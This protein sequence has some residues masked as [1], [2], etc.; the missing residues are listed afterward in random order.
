[1][2]DRAWL[3]TIETTHQGGVP[4][5]VDALYRMMTGWGVE[6]TVTW[7]QSVLEDVTP[8]GRIVRTWQRR[9]PWP[10]AERGDQRVLLVP[11]MPVPFWLSYL[12]PHYFSNR[13]FNRQ[14][15]IFVVS[16]SAH[17]A[18]P[19]ALRGIPYL[20]W[21]GTRYEDELRA[22]AEAGE[23]WARRVLNS[24]TWGIA[25]AQERLALRRAWRVLTNG[26]VTA[27]R[28]VE[29]APDI[30]D[31]VESALAP[32]DAD[33]FMPDPAA[34]AVSSYGDYLLLVG[35]IGDVRK[36]VGLLIR[37]FQ[38]VRDHLPHLKLVL[39][40]EPPSEPVRQ[41]I[42]SLDLQ[43]AVILTDVIPRGDL[44]KLFQGALLF[45]LPSRQEGLGIVLL[46]AMAC[47]TPVVAT[48]CGGPEG[49]IVDGHNGRLVP[50]DDPEAMA[51]AIL[52]LMRNP[53]RLETMRQACRSFVEQNADV[54]VIEP[55]VRALWEAFAGGSSES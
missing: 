3:L 33:F 46:E 26:P 7:A 21:I 20:L 36:N 31:R 2:A 9:A 25:Q 47:G 37:A 12:T 28:C 41:L 42:E 48:R 32:V 30:A 34:R 14:T 1:V 23:D 8:W 40:G 15:P 55:R 13:L 17:V 11:A 18:L 44:L 38:K 10:S 5:H 6:P 43:Q 35:R 16:G 39:A 50:L 19:L 52:D 53:D 54:R 4:S 29:A 45:V 49:I 22:R 51:A 27:R 24:P